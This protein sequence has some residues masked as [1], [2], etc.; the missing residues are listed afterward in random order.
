M[1]PCSARGLQHPLRLP[2]GGPPAQLGLVSQ[3]CLYTCE[4]KRQRTAALQ[5]A[6]AWS[7]APE[8]AKRLGVRLSSAAFWFARRVLLILRR[9]ARGFENHP[10]EANSTAAKFGCWAIRGSGAK[11]GSTGAG[12]RGRT[13]Q[14]LTGIRE[15]CHGETREDGNDSRTPQ[16]HGRVGPAGLPAWRDSSDGQWASGRQDPPGS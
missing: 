11:G 4:A 9:H 10:Q 1:R 14:V 3:N 2:V 8:N 16:P 15:L 13:R 12:M 6:D 5:D 7:H